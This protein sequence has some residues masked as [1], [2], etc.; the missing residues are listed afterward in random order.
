MHKANAIE[1]KLMLLYTFFFARN[2]KKISV[3]CKKKQRNLL[4]F[5]LKKG[6]YKY[7][8]CVKRKRLWTHLKSPTMNHFSM[9][10]AETE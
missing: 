4:K 3:E 8:G 1:R 10:N 6:T 7:I 9:L 2:K 5:L